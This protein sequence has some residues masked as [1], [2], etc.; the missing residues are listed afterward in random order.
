MST[1]HRSDPLRS[2]EEWHAFSTGPCGLKLSGAYCRERAAE[3]LDDT[4]PSTRSFVGAYGKKYRDSVVSW[5]E[6]AASEAT[7]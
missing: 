7:G 6:R 4:S 5:F 1:N 3:L 2:Y